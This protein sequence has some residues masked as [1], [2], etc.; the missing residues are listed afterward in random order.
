[1]TRVAVPRARPAGWERPSAVTS[2]L[3]RRG[4]LELVA[5]VDPA[6]CRSGSSA[7]SRGVDSPLIVAG[8]ERHASSTPAPRWSSI[9]TVAEAALSNL[10]FAAAKLAIH[11]VCGT[12]GLGVDA[13]RE[14]REAF[15]QAGSAHC[16]L[17]PNFAISAVLAMHLA[18]VAA[19][20]FD[21]AE[22]IELHHDEKRDAPSGTAIETARRNAAAKAASGEGF[23]PDPTTEV[24]LPGARGGD[25]TGGVRVHSVRL[26]GLIAHEEILFGA[27]GQSLTIRLDSYDRAS[28]LPGVLL[29]IRRVGELP[30][31]TVGLDALLGLSSPRR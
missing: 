23:R 8:V 11:A 31:L 30:G 19:P 5:A 17:A 29:A 22:V 20:F 15:P 26:H 14:L 12:T 27:L 25:G 4:D 24:V 21:S 28:F 18:E 10:K 1:M 3:R 7:R 2:R 9:S 13:L 6:A 16:V